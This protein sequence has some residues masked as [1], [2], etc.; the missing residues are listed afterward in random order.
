MLRLPYP[1]RVIERLRDWRKGVHWRDQDRV[2]AET[3]G[4]SGSYIQTV[5]DGKNEH[6]SNR[7]AMNLGIWPVYLDLKTGDI[8]AV[9]INTVPD[10]PEMMAIR[11]AIT[12][13]K[14][15]GTLDMKDVYARLFQDKE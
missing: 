7:S 11:D 10:L 14:V 6:P 4:L 3:T 9:P 2:A 1:R 12:E 15:L 8:V 5:V 13:D